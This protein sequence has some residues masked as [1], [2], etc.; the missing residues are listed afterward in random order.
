MF[1]RRCSGFEELLLGLFVFIEGDQLIFEQMGQFIEFF[2]TGTAGAVQLLKRNIR[3]SFQGR[4]T[5]I[6]PQP[7]R[8]NSPRKLISTARP[9]SIG[10]WSV[11]RNVLPSAFIFR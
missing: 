3:T 1:I 8:G 6:P 7:Y 9:L 10:D 2:D 5:V 11:S 4:P